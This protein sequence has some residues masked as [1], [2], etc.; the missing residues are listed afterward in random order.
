MKHIGI[1][2]VTYQGASLLYNSIC[3]IGQQKLGRNCHPEISFHTPPR[4]RFLRKRDNW[5][6]Y[7]AELLL[8]STKRLVASGAECIACASNT[9]HEA[10]PYIEERSPIPWVHIADS[11]AADVRRVVVGDVVCVG[12]ARVAGGY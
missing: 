6:K 7:W 12:A 5:Q 2:G 3:E 9:A 11:V 8:D 1:I 4:E 10:Y